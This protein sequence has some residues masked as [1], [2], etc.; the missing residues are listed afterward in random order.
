MHHNYDIVARPSRNPI[1]TSYKM[2]QLTRSV[3][4]AWHAT[5]RWNQES[6][7]HNRYYVARG[8]EAA[9]ARPQEVASPAADPG[10]VT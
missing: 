4:Q 9:N 10:R 6:E 3:K 1:L 5:H 2:N 8:G 7:T